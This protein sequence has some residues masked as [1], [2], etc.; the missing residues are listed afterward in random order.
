MSDDEE[1]TA[2]DFFD[3]IP[4]CTLDE[5]IEVPASLD[6]IREAWDEFSRPAWNLGCAI[7]EGSTELLPTEEDELAFLSERKRKWVEF[8]QAYEAMCEAMDAMAAALRAIP[9]TP[10]LPECLTSLV[11]PRGDQHLS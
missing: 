4:T 7:T 1:N 2:E 9:E 10:P 3:S 5:S 11:A 6:A 8:V